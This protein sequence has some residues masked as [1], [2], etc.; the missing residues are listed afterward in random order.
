M[1]VRRA[2]QR[3][4][5]ER[6]A[7]AGARLSVITVPGRSA[8]IAR[9]A[10][11]GFARFARAPAK[12][13]CQL[14]V[15]RA[16]GSLGVGRAARRSKAYRATSHPPSS[17]PS[18]LNHG[19]DVRLARRA[20]PRRRPPRARGICPIHDRLRASSVP[21]RRRRSRATHRALGRRLPRPRRRSRV[22]RCVLL[23]PRLSSRHRASST[24][25]PRIGC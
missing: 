25:R 4:G 9:S 1:W 6:T 10:P 2:V 16:R 22:Q 12:I 21:R 19:P 3:V 11:A 20:R 17:R 7:G 5:S 14:S 13:V 8:T 24:S 23:T 18:P 15:P